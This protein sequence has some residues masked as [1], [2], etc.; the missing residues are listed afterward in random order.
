MD[1]LFVM[2]SNVIPMDKP[3]QYI[4][5]APVASWLVGLLAG[6]L[7]GRIFDRLDVRQDGFSSG[8]VEKLTRKYSV[9]LRL[10]NHPTRGDGR[11][12]FA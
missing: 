4:L 2:L 6:W 3:C 8:W 5:D 10:V 11:T 7:A 9:C 12:F 1:C